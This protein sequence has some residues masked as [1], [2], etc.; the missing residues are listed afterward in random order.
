MSSAGNTGYKVIRPAANPEPLRGHIG[1]L[2]QDALERIMFKLSW[3]DMH[4]FTGMIVAAPKLMQD[5]V[6]DDLLNRCAV[7][8]GTQAFQEDFEFWHLFRQMRNVQ[9]R[10]RGMRL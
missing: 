5:V 1:D 2:P 9:D 10:A 8:E 4:G 7:G 6:G 3:N